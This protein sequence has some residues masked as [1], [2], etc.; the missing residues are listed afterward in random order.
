[1]SE[2]MDFNDGK[3]T[4]IH[5]DSGFRALR[6]GGPWRNLNG[7]HLVYSMLLEITKLKEER[8]T[9]AEWK[10]QA[11]WLDKPFKAEAAL[12]EAALAEEVR[13][14]VQ[15]VPDH[16]DRITWRGSYYHLP[17]PSKATASQPGANSAPIEAIGRILTEVMD[18]AV[19]NGAGSRSMP[20][21][22]VEVAAW[23]CG[24]GT[25]TPQPDADGWIPWAGGECPLGRGVLHQVR[26]RN[27][28][29][30]D[31]S[32]YPDRWHWDHNGSATDLIA[33]RVVEA[34]P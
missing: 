11:E 4:V 26:F 22:Y 9:L 2:Q 16:C 24:V 31:W 17:I 30:S 33:Y 28:D 32:E 13:A 19:R 23:L 5:D 10:Q 12:A 3:Y 27:G 15:A 21:D 7:D 6:Y 1:M 18:E 8:D 20:D 29:G 25:K 34:Q 14:Y